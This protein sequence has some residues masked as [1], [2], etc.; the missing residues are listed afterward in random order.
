VTINDK[1]KFSEWSISD[2]VGFVEFL[3]SKTVFMSC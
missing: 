1:N 3:V 2:R